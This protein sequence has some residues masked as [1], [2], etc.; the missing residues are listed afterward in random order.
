MNSGISYSFAALMSRVR[1]NV[2]GGNADR[3][4]RRLYAM[5]VAQARQTAF[6]EAGGVPDTMEGRFDMI[7]LHLCLVLRRLRGEDGAATRAGQALFNAF[8]ADMDGNLREM[9]VGDLAVPK[10][11]K[12][13]GEAFYGRAAAYDAALDAQGDTPLR[14]A[15]VRNVFCDFDA[16]DLAGALARYVRKAD[17]QLAALPREVLLALKWQFPALESAERVATVGGVHGH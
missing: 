14:E 13:F 2:V 5:V 6:Y 10:R 16:V 7:V 12:K 15:L 8:C 4:A 1:A 17:R 3:Q 9:G 11:M